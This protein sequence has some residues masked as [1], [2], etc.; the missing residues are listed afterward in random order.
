MSKTYNL[1]SK[2]RFNFLKS[3]ETVLIKKQKSKAIFM[4]LLVK[5]LIKMQ[6]KSPNYLL[7]YEKKKH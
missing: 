4:I 7:K 1:L 3:F 2:E 6:K 5:T